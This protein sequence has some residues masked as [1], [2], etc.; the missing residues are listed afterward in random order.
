MTSGSCEPSPP[1]NDF[2]ALLYTK[3][4][5]CLFF[6][7]KFVYDQRKIQTTKDKPMKT[8]PIA[9]AGAAAIAFIAAC[10]NDKFVA[11]E[12]AREATMQP[13][14]AE[15]TAL[16]PDGILKD[17]MAGNEQF[18]TNQQSSSNVGNRRAKATEGQYPKAYILSCVDS[19]VPVEQVFNQ[20]IGDLFVG[21]VAG[22]IETAEQLGSMEFATALSGVKVV[23]VLGHEACGAVKGAAD[24]AKLGNLTTLLEQITPAVDGV[25]GFEADRSSKNKEFIGSIIE[26]NVAM[27][28]ADIRSRST[29]L[30]NLEKDGK[31]MI[32]GAVYSLTTGKVSLVN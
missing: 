6:R 18:A 2:Q 10:S 8:L 15:Q 12:E 22:N 4:V 19:R 23:M 20:G 14:K 28:V 16:T 3:P 21:R 30:A 31:I 24:N 29:V 32:V 5:A 13:T 26:K 1:K 27:T 7:V 17:L 11:T 25:E 9:L